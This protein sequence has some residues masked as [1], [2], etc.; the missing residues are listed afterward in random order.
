SQTVTAFKDEQLN[1]ANAHTNIVVGHLLKDGRTVVA[2]LRQAV[3]EVEALNSSLEMQHGT[4]P[5]DADAVDLM[6]VRRNGTQAKAK[7]IGLD[8][9]TGLSLLQ[10][11]DA[12]PSSSARLVKEASTEVEQ[13]VFAMKKAGKVGEEK[14]LMEQQ[15]VRLFAPERIKEAEAE[16]DTV[17]IRLNEFEG[18]LVDPQSALFEGRS[19]EV[20]VP[21]SHLW[22]A[23]DGAVALSRAGEFVGIVERSRTSSSAYLVPSDIVDQAVKR[24]LTRRASVPQPWL[25][26]RGDAVAMTTLANLLSRGWPR[27]QAFEMMQRGQGVLLTAVPPNTPAA[28]AGLR[29]G[30]VVAR[31]GAHSIR[32]VD[33]FSRLLRQAGPNV[34]VQFTVWRTEGKPRVITVELREAFDPVKATITALQLAEHDGTPHSEHRASYAKNSLILGF[35]AVVMLPAGVALNSSAPSSLLVIFVRPESAAASSGLRPG[36]QIVSVDGKPLPETKSIENPF[37]QHDSVLTLGVLRNSHP[38]TL[39]LPQPSTN[40]TKRK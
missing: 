18:K 17:Y 30:D 24:V 22:H 12:L 5:V 19:L 16:A 10:V 15:A 29:A 23:I 1:E 2:R 34:P 8:A 35:E 14:L 4:N 11:D 20:I 9:V 7:F 27:Q 37:E 31:I 36:D 39:T 3:I 13:K 32:G 21:S 33:D 26:A 6:V 38:L 40:S 25:G 28:I